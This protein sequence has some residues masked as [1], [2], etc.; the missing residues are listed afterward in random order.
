MQARQITVE[1]AKAVAGTGG[2]VGL[3]AL[4]PTAEKYVEGIRE[5]AD[6]V[7][8]DH[9]G[10]GRDGPVSSAPKPWSDLPEGLMYGVIGLMLKQ[11]FTPEEC[12]KIAGGNAC[13]V[14]KA[15]L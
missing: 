10:I 5:M 4:F 9:V 12:G 6:V 2:V 13:R 1:H 11:G 7:G 8:V 3:W 14:I 15:C